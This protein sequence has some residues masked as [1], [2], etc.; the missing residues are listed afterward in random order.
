MKKRI[1]RG[2]FLQSCFILCLS[3]IIIMGMLYKYF[4][5]ITMNEIKNELT[6]IS[7]GVEQN[8]KE[9][10]EKLGKVDS[11][12]TWIQENGDIIYDSEMNED[13]MENHKD[14]QEV[15]E[16][17]KAGS[18]ESYRFSNTMGKMSYY[19][20]T[21]LE[22]NS[23]LRISGTR[24]TVISL[25]MGLTTPF[26][27][28]LSIAFIISIF[29]SRKI[30]ENITRPINEIDLRNIDKV[31][32]Y[33]E[34]TPFIRKI[35][36]QNKKIQSQVN[37]LRQ[38]QQEFDTITE[39]MSEGLLVFDKNTDVIF[40]NTSALKLLGADDVLGKQS[41]YVL[42]RSEAFVN[43]VNLA[44]SGEHS[45]CNIKLD[46]RIYQ[47]IANPVYNENHLAGG[48]I[49]IVDVTEKEE[50]EN[51]RREFSANVSHE[52][53]TPLTSISGFAE[54]MKSGIVPEED[55]KKF[56]GN[57]YNEAKR[58]ITLV[59][60]I[61]KLSKFDEN[62]GNTEFED[63]DFTGIVNDNIRRLTQVASEKSVVIESECD[64]VIMKGIPSVIDEM[65]Y[66]LIENAIKYNKED[67]KVIVILKETDGKIKFSVEDTG[68]GIPYGEQP[69]VFERFY[70]VDKSHSKEIGGTGL[71][72]SIVKHG[73]ATHNG[74]IELVSEPEK[75]TKITVVF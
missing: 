12:I 58:L 73:A 38:K 32:T 57:I 21:L 51:L 8:G 66:N 11:R 19:Y 41:V 50:R 72:L 23:V 15:I 3:V 68:I 24:Y 53:K 16:A 36:H 67:G 65:V 64:D 74:N 42:N 5:K 52:L 48:I 60:D 18:G 62:S 7:A 20:A 44:L 28:V 61:I 30:S 1:F 26:L 27:L 35:A 75:G 29:V 56:A 37:E 70:R 17:L 69:R 2:M 49:I 31:D 9:Y 55:M 22:D 14:R 46:E 71:G 47:I 33:E 45:E 4:S 59:G 25:L 10:L 40:Y 34:L 43:A 54:I 6:F 39:N 63:I 13:E